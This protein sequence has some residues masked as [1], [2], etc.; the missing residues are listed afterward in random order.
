MDRSLKNHSLALDFHQRKAVFETGLLP[1]PQRFPGVQAPNK[2]LLKK[3]FKIEETAS[4]LNPS[5]IYY[6][7]FFLSPNKQKEKQWLQNRPP[8]TCKTRD[9]LHPNV[10]PPA[11]PPYLARQSGSRAVPCR[12][13]YSDRKQR[14]GRVKL[15]LVVA[16]RDHQPF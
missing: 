8:K 13:G 4:N 7:C 5:S 6:I 2:D 3:I 15:R 14:P 9:F 1:S 12:G 11:P 10:S 16:G